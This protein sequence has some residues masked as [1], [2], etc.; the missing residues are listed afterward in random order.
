MKDFFLFWILLAFVGVALWGIAGVAWVLIGR[1]THGMPRGSGPFE[2]WDK[3]FGW[4]LAWLGTL[5]LIGTTLFGGVMAAVNDLLITPSPVA[6]L[7][8]I[9]TTLTLVVVVRSAW[10]IRESLETASLALTEEPD[11]DGPHAVVNSFRRWAMEPLGLTLCSA[12]VYAFLAAVVAIAIQILGGGATELAAV[13]CL[14]SAMIGEIFTFCG[15]LI[16]TAAEVVRLPEETLSPLQRRRLIGMLRGLMISFGIVGAIG[17]GWFGLLFGGLMVVIV[18]GTLGGRW[19]AGQL[20]AFWTVA[21]VLRSGRSIELEL[22]GQAHVTRGRARSL[23]NTA[24]FYL[25]KGEALDETLCRRGLAPQAV[26]LEV[27]AATSANSL[28][29]AIQLCAARET[30]KFSRQ[31]NEST[32]RIALGYL[33]S[34]VV[35]LLLTTSF[36]GY[37]IVPKLKR[38]FADFDMELP[39]SSQ[40]LFSLMG[41]GSLM[42]F[43]L[44]ALLGLAGLAAVGEILVSFYGWQ[45]AM[46]RLGIFSG[47]SGRTSDLL[48]G[49]RWAVL[50]GQSIDAA[51]LAMS[52]APV[53]FACRSRLHRAATII[54]QGHDP[55]DTLRHTGWLTIPQ[56]V[57]LQTAQAAGNL[58]WA[59]EAMSDAIV[60]RSEYRLNWWL[61]VL[62]PVFILMAGAAVGYIALGMLMPL[63]S[64]INGLS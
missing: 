58:P 32:P 61:Q 13:G 31:G 36:I 2:G 54:E 20:S 22:R 1:L 10:T 29:E 48:R 46:D 8:S 34:V 30:E 14:I 41:D 9:M 37:Y 33:T 44:L 35:I 39:H 47:R 18:V 49:L 26:W 24:S 23:L 55:W 28:S 7:V 38:I 53:G 42:L 63:F 62:H 52:R 45:G 15:L 6:I 51:L 17:F 40:Q 21:H 59:L 4:M 64:L 60:A 19:R 27:S 25:E 16:V 50:R 12:L 11:E 43:V 3:L 57:L 56:A 5:W